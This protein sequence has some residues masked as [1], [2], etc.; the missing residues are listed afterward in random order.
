MDAADPTK[1]L[2]NLGRWKQHFSALFE[3]KTQGMQLL[4]ES[5]QCLFPP[6]GFMAP[7]EN[8]TDFFIN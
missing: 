5:Q 4:T 7:S 8:F 6:E 3:S 1:I 2:N